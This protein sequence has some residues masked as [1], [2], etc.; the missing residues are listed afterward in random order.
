MND[1]DP[2]ALKAAIDHVQGGIQH[3]LDMDALI[4]AAIR[5]YQKTECKPMETIPTDGRVFEAW[6]I[7]SET[8][9]AIIFATHITAT[10]C[11]KEFAGVIGRSG[12]QMQED[13]TCWRE[14]WKPKGLKL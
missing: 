3:C 9:V 13:F 4:A 12:D 7:C 14:Q 1:L 5:T 11:W 2:E 8:W 6:E 10:K